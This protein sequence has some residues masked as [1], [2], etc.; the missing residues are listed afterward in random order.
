MK[1]L[2]KFKVIKHKAKP[3]ITYPLVR[4]PRPEVHRA[5]DTV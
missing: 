4:L 1:L 3:E 2:G 5:G